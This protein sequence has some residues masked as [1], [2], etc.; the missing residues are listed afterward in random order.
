MDVATFLVSIRG[1]L[2]M[3]RV[4]VQH[5]ICKLV[6]ATMSMCFKFTLQSDLPP[7][8]QVFTLHVLEYLFHLLNRYVSQRKKY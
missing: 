2:G 7:P 5:M 3:E 1:V 6:E 4:Q 8:C